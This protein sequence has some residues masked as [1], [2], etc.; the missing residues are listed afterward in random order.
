MCGTIVRAVFYG[1]HVVRIEIPRV[2][3]RYVVVQVRKK[4]LNVDRT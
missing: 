2:E 3:V 4:G 1:S